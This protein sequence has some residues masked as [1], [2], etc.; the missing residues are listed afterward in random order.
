M[1]HIFQTRECMT[2]GQPTSHISEEMTTESPKTTL[3]D[4]PALFVRLGKY[5]GRQR[6]EFIEEQ[7]IPLG[8]WLV[9]EGAKQALADEDVVL[10]PRCDTREIPF[11]A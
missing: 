3:A 7:R 10:P 11:A 6:P 8:T 4:V 9:E 1:S 5:H 2:A